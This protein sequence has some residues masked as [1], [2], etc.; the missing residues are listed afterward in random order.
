M[1]QNLQFFAS[2]NFHLTNLDHRCLCITNLRKWSLRYVRAIVWC[3]WKMAFGALD[4]HFRRYPS[5][6]YHWSSKPEQMWT[7]CSRISQT[8]VNVVHS[9][10]GVSWGQDAMPKAE[11]SHFVSSAHF[12]PYVSSNSWNTWGPRYGWETTPTEV[13]EV[14]LK[15]E[16]NIWREGKKAGV[17]ADKVFFWKW[18]TYALKTSHEI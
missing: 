7:V 4:N 8:C 17:T 2:E 10:V 14:W 11:Q 13:L 5:K 16:G 12:C 9:S 6:A 18:W 15:S 1:I 3:W